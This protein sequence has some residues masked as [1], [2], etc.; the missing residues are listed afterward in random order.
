MSRSAG[1]LVAAGTAGNSVVSA[2]ASSALPLSGVLPSSADKESP[3]SPAPAMS[4]E[5]VSGPSVGFVGGGVDGSAGFL[6]G[7]SVVGFAGA[8]GS[9]MGWLLGRGVAALGPDGS[10][11][12]QT[13][14]AAS[15][16]K[17]ERRCPP[18]SQE[19]GTSACAQRAATT[20]TAS[21]SSALQTISPVI[22]PAARRSGSARSAS[23]SRAAGPVTSTLLT[24]VFIETCASDFAPRIPASTSETASSTSGSWAPTVRSTSGSG[25]RVTWI[26]PS[27][28]HDQTSSVANGRYG[29]S[30]RSWTDKATANAAFADSAGAEP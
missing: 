13:G 10:A 16:L 20:L 11:P 28:H 23:A 30:N 1:Q 21:E 15:S 3:A 24:S 17:R 5:R 22:R 9:F 12:R 29:A 7:A 19:T 25:Q 18:P 2:E 27:C 8:V 6:G 4:A 14:S 26:E